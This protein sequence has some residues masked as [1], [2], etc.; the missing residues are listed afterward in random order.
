MFVVDDLL[1]RATNVPGVHHVLATP[2]LTAI[3]VVLI[4]MLVAYL[5]VRP[6]WKGGSFWTSYLRMGIYS[7]VGSMVVMSLH[8]RVK[9]SEYRKAGRAE[10]DDMAMAQAAEVDI[11]DVEAEFARFHGAA[12]PAAQIPPAPHVPQQVP[13]Q[14][15]VQQVQQQ[16]TPMFVQSP[17]PPIAMYVAQP[18]MPQPPPAQMLYMQPMQ[19]GRS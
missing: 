3:L 5:T 15:Q 17:P 13:Q 4:F 18:Q 6:H 16:A 1:E 11:G 10:Q 8:H 12:T 7:L 19:Q 14:A 9:S 2:I